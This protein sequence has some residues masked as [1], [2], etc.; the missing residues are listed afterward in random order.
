MKLIDRFMK[1][2][3]PP[4]RSKLSEVDDDILL[5]L[6]RGHSIKQIHEYITGYRKI[7]VELKY[8]HRYIKKLQARD[9]SKE[10]VATTVSAEATTS[11][12]VKIDEPAQEPQKK[13]SLL[14]KTAAFLQAQKEAGVEPAPIGYYKPKTLMIDILDKQ[15]G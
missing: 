15:D 2:N 7:S 1:S 6:N 13:M 14:E 5:L 8:L 3:K 4:Q 9:K 12:M 10:T 11:T